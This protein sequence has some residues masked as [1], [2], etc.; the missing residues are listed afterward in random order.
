MELKTRMGKKVQRG[1]T[2]H[3]RRTISHHRMMMAKILMTTTMM[4]VTRTTM[5]KLMAIIVAA[6]KTRTE[7][8]PI[9]KQQK[10]LRKR[11]LELH[12]ATTAIPQ[13]NLQVVPVKTRVATTMVVAVVKTKMK[14]RTLLLHSATLAIHRR[15]CQISLVL[16]AQVVVC[17]HGC[18]HPNIPVAEFYTN[19]AA[20]AK[21]YSEKHP[22]EAVQHNLSLMKTM[23][24]LI[25]GLIWQSLMSTWSVSIRITCECI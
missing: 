1:T 9:Q 13:L 16:V 21:T 24:Q 7:T 14:T 18:F 17:Y 20:I 11:N 5:I 6:V 8:M 3:H 2:V 4:I 15:F 19:N 22:S 12:L 23:L 10:N 25:L